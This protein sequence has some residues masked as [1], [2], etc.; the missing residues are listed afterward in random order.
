MRTKAPGHS[1]SDGPEK[2]LQSGSGEGQYRYMIFV[3]EE[4]MQSHTYFS[5][6]FLLVSWRF[7]LVTGN[8]H[9]QERFLCFLRYEEIQELGS[10]ISYWDY[11]SEDLFFKSFLPL[12][13]ESAHFCSLPWTLFSGCW[14]SAAAAAHDLILVEVGGKHPWQVP[15]CSWQHSA[16][17]WNHRNGPWTVTTSASPSSALGTNPRWRPAKASSLVFL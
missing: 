3:K 1:T 9:H 16:W 11:L 17:V 7:L 4:Y 13:T 10:S 8:S 15:I 5:R 14:R 6:K 2:L 12:P